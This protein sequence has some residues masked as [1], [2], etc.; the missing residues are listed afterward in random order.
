MSDD[1]HMITTQW[2][3]EVESFA[4]L[5]D[6][7]RRVLLEHCATF[8]A[9]IKD[10]T[11]V[12]V[13]LSYG[14]LLGAARTGKMISYDFDIDLGFHVN[15]SEKSVIVSKCRDVIRY[16]TRTCHRVEVESNG[17][18][19]A[20]KLFNNSVYVSIELFV[21]WVEDDNFYL[22]FGIPGAPITEDILPLGEIEIEGVKLPAPKHPETMLE[23]IYGPDWHIPDP[24]FKYE[25]IE[26]GPFQGFS[27]QRNKVYWE[28][29]YARKRYKHVWAEFPSQFAAFCAS[30]IEAGSKILDF[31]CGNGR[32]SLFLSQIG[33]DVVACDYAKAGVELVK[34]KAEAKQLELD[35]QILNIYDTSDVQKFITANPSEYDVIYSRFV[36]HAITAEGQDR[37]LRLTKKVL[38]ESGKV[39]LEFRNSEDVRKDIG[40]V[41]SEDERSDGHYRR[42]IKTDDF[43]AN[44]KEVGFDVDY[45]AEGTGFAKFKD[46]DPNVTRLVLS[47]ASE[48]DV[49]EN[50]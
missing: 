41:I 43:L 49:T 35:A 24:N 33:H 21:S 39:I 50:V 18:F 38:K 14:C 34:E 26:W 36:M 11:G 37:F 46:E 31:G 48:E 7:A 45:L 4:A 10:N 19:K 29:Y 42:F 13:Y 6:E 32:D 17:Q 5:S 44:V 23:A 47:H 12:D 3:T 27:V 30:E 1:K 15:S 2:G 16:L 8:M 40:D 22:Y 28:E 20:A 25:N 9:E